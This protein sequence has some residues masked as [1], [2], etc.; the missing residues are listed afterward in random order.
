[1]GFPIKREFISGR[2]GTGIE[3]EGAFFTDTTDRRCRIRRKKKGGNVE[4]VYMN[5]E[6]EMYFVRAESFISWSLM[7]NLKFTTQCGFK[8][9]VPPLIRQEGARWL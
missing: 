3:G 5:S 7:G 6:R 9:G 4:K 2:R 8:A 1:L